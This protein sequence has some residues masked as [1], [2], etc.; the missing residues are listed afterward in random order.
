M[1][2][3]KKRKITQVE[4]A[5][6]VF[7]RT[8]SILDDI[9]MLKSGAQGESTQ[10][11][12]KD[13]I[14]ECTMLFL[15]L[16]HFN[17]EIV[18]DVEKQRTEINKERSKL[19]PKNLQLQNLLYQKEHLRQ[20][21]AS[22]R[23]FRSKESELDLISEDEVL[24]IQTEK[25]QVL[26]N[27][28]NPAQPL[29][30]QQSD[31]EKMLTRLNVELEMRKS[32]RVQIQELEARKK[33]LSE[34]LAQ[35]RKSIESLN[36]KF[37]GLKQ[38]IAAIQENIHTSNPTKEIKISTA[39]PTANQLPLPLYTLYHSLLAF[40][41]VSEPNLI[42]RLESAEEAQLDRKI[43]STQVVTIEF[44]VENT[45]DNDNSMKTDAIVTLRF[46]HFTA[47]NTVGCSIKSEG[48]GHAILSAMYA[49]DQGTKIDANYRSYRWLDHIAGTTTVKLAFKDGSPIADLLHKIKSK[50]QT[51]S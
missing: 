49:D 23:D 15:E 43:A 16:K 22:C 20:Q 28:D 25:S 11:K 31:H 6:N 12:Q 38:S 36:N 9:M 33:A 19:D 29:I 44:P 37:G 3:S 40:K 32:L 51:K 47:N 13:L 41:D 48:D 4:D 26:P 21:I 46:A 17:R 2:N 45:E 8:K 34:V 39:L 27:N 1:E 35:K 14:K 10:N 50:L 24:V 30:S 18:T 5:E 42:V 7:T